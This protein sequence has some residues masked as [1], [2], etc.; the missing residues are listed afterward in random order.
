[1]TPLD[2]AGMVALLVS[3]TVTGSTILACEIRTRT[4]AHKHTWEPIYDM[5]GDIT[6]RICTSCGQVEGQRQW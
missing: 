1:M 5:Q 3:A 4:V 6:G 2:Y